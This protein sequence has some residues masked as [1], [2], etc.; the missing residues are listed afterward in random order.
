M[1]EIVISRKMVFDLETGSCIL[2]QALNCDMGYLFSMWYV[3]KFSVLNRNFTQ[4][5]WYIDGLIQEKRNSIANAMEL[6]LS[7]INPSIYK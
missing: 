2:I 4:L 5:R 7:C 1:A 3:V 6:R